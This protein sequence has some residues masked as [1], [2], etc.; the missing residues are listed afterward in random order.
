MFYFTSFS[1]LISGASSSSLPFFHL[2]MHFCF[3]PTHKTPR[4]FYKTEQRSFPSRSVISFSFVIVKKKLPKNR[5]IAAKSYTSGNGASSV[6]KGNCDFFPSLWSPFSTLKVTA[7]L[8]GAPQ[9]LS[10]LKISQLISE[11]KRKV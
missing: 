10:S 1:V 9:L 8:F 4:L 5:Y 7:N 2:L 3:F 11:M 6:N